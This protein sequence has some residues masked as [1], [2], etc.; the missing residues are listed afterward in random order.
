MEKFSKL[1]EGVLINI[2]GG[3]GDQLDTQCLLRTRGAL[4]RI[5]A[6]YRFKGEHGT[7]QPSRI[8]YRAKNNRAGYLAAFGERHAYLPYLQLKS[9]HALKPDALPVPHGRKSELT[10]TSLG[11]GACIELYGIC[12]FYMGDRQQ[13]LYLKLN[14]VERE[15]EWVSNRQYVFS[16]VLKESFPKLDIDPIDIPIDLRKDVISTLARSYDRL[17]DTDILL[18]YNVMN[19]IPSNYARTVWKNIKFLLDIFQ[20]PVLILLMEPSSERAEPRIHWLKRH[21]AQEAEI[22]NS[23][24]EEHYAFNAVPVCIEMNTSDECLNYRLFGMRIGGS[25]LTFE[26]TIR[27]S[28]LA[29]IKRPNSPISMEQVMK[30]LS[31]LDI[32]RGRR[33]AFLSRH[34]LPEQQPSFGDISP[35]WVS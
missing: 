13:P 14:W 1:L 12:L 19:E 34:N 20:R 6:I 24:K 3:T 15:H 18:V 26:T 21:L 30:Q 25:K 2:W 31:D 29:C 23:G 5:R 28:H 33:G 9:I 17:I 22:I 11:A 4:A 7:I 35:E 32:K 8:N 10:I 27:R 16:K